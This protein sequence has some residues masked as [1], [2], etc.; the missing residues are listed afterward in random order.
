MDSIGIVPSGS[1]VSEGNLGLKM[2]ISK[3]V[4]FATQEY[5][6]L[7]L[8]G[9]PDDFPLIIDLFFFLYGIRGIETSPVSAKGSSSS[10][11]VPLILEED[12][13]SKT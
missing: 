12:S 4:A 8:F 7:L 2:G 9:R 13:M 6:V 5:M 10:I 11:M 1:C 3:F